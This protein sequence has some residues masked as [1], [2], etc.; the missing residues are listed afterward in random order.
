MPPSLLARRRA[1]HSGALLPLSGLVRFRRES[2]HSTS[3]L[4]SGYPPRGI[5]VGR[6]L[7]PNDVDVTPQIIQLV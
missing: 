1:S 5:Y 6:D 2:G 7:T 3:Y 4:F